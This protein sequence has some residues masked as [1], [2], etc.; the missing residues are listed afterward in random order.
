M[1]ANLN[2]IRVSIELPASVKLFTASTII[3]TSGTTSMS[4]AVML[5]HKNICSNVYD[6]S[7]IF[8]LDEND[9]DDLNDSDSDNLSESSLNEIEMED[10]LNILSSSIG[11]LTNPEKLKNTFKSVK[12]SN[13]TS[14]TIKKY[15]T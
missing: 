11:S 12:K 8:D 15:I 13:V 6:V 7:T 1:L 3:F 9:T 14:N 2:P 10:L 4:K 5:S